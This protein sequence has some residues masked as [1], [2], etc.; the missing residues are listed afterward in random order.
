[1]PS[2]PL[3]EEPGVAQFPGIDYYNPRIRDIEDARNFS[4]DVLQRDLMPRMPWHD[5]S[6]E[7]WGAPARDLARHFISQWNFAVLDNDS[8]KCFPIFPCNEFEL[9]EEEEVPSNPRIASSNG[10]EAESKRRLLSRQVSAF[11]FKKKVIS[12]N[13]DAN[14][15]FRVKCQVIRTIPV[16]SGV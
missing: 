6:M 8:K 13:F 15:R 12:S 5:V 3:Y 2:H 9:N 16:W 10:S 7:Y 11:A 14:K 4:S 1:M